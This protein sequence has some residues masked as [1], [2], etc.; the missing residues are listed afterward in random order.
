MP[1]T[2]K[3]IAV[4]PMTRDAITP[5]DSSEGGGSR[6]SHDRLITR[7]IALIMAGTFFYMTSSMM[8]TPCLLYT[9]PSPRD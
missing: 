7:D 6:R 8:G 3:E 9:S 2:R 5:K 1:E 4:Q